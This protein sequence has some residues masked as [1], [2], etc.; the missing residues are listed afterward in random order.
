MTDEL[1]MVGAGLMGVSYARAARRLGL[2]VR[3]VGTERHARQMG[4]LADEVV[5]TAGGPD[6]VWAQAALAAARERRPDGVLAFSEPHV[7]AAALV[8]ERYGLPGPSTH[9]AVLSR[10]KAL[11]RAC[12][13][14]VGLPQPEYRVTDDLAGAREW[15]EARLPVVVKPLSASASFGVELVADESAF[16][17]AV[18]RRTGR[19]RLLVETYVHG[20]EFSWEGLLKDGKLL[21]GNL[22]AKETS[23]APQFVERGHRPAQR[24]SGPAADTFDQL[25]PRLVDALGMRTGIVHLEFRL[26]DDG[27]YVVEVAVRTPGDFIPDVISMAYGFD[28]Y[29]TVVRLAMGL[30]VGDLPAG[31]APRAAA[32]WFPVAEPG[33]VSAVEGLAD[34]R[35]HPAVR[36]AVVWAAPGDEIAPLVSS[37]DRVGCVLLEGDDE[38][39][40]QRAAEFVRDRLRVVTRRR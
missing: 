36:S 13:G 3:L 23:G 28:V 5:P 29:E 20:P 22:T 18:R 26:A 35:A 27:P 8:Q 32:S 9:A 15:A 14:A 21:F 37:S 6:E 17:D 2:R 40:V 11:Q 39:E 34:V 33:I 38:Q 31:A 10:N 25:V 24:L 7:M 16:D 1:L 4:D 12:F 30:P 19:G